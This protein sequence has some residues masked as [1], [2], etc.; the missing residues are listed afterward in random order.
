METLSNLVEVNLGYN[1]IREIS[2][3][4]FAA[5]TQLRFL[6]LNNNVIKSLANLSKLSNLSALNMA[7]NKISELFEVEKIADCQNLCELV[8]NGNF[9]SQKGIY[10]LGI[11]RRMP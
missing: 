10:R 2:S 3:H 5:N 9:V 7:N 1:K 11:I 6:R 8:L 4:S